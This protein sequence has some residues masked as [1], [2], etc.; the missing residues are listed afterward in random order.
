MEGLYP[1]VRRPRRPLVRVAEAMP[2]AVEELVETPTASTP[3]A[4]VE[5]AAV[6]VQPDEAVFQKRLAGSAVVG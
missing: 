3:E 6:E 4:R 5:E 1:I 2:A